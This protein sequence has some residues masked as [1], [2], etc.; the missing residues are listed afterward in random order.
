FT[1]E[2]FR[3]SSLPAVYSIGNVHAYCDNPWSSDLPN[4]QPSGGV[5]CTKF[6]VA[7]AWEF[8][9][10]G[11]ANRSYTY[12]W[13]NDD[14]GESWSGPQTSPL[15]PWA[16]YVMIGERTYRVL[17]GS[18]LGTGRDFFYDWNTGILTTQNEAQDFGTFR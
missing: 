3:G 17:D 13:K 15:G 2:T 1:R 5:P 11:I 6:W 7:E 8:T 9:S 4:P 12:E 18:F 10:F 16:P 14:T